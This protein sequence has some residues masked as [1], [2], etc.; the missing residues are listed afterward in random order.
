M[1]ENRCIC[2]SLCYWRYNGNVLMTAGIGD[3]IETGG[4]V[5]SI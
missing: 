3:I 1:T 4:A 5:T 2:I